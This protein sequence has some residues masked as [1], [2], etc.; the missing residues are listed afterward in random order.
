[1]TARV[2]RSL[3]ARHFPPDCKLKMASGVDQTDASIYFSRLFANQQAPR[4]RRASLR[5]KLQCFIR[6]SSERAT[7]VKFER[8]AFN[9]FESMKIFVRWRYRRA[10]FRGEAD[11]ICL[12]RDIDR[13]LVMSGYRLFRLPRSILVP[14]ERRVTRDRLLKGIRSGLCARKSRRR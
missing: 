10:F 2:I 4:S 14:E 6:R 3:I 1:M 11:E 9:S 7:K 12:S 13:Q 5:N 8:V